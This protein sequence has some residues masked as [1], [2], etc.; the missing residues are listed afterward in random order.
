MFAIQNIKTGKFVYG[1]D[2]RYSP[3]H[4]RTSFNQYFVYCSLADAK[5]DFKVRKCCKDYRVVSLEP[6]RIMQIIA[7]DT[8]SGYKIYDKD[9]TIKTII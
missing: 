1:T 3:P 4:Q 5:I 9:W 6:A 8:E 7:F 2:Y